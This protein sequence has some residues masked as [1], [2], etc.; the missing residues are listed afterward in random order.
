MAS[1]ARV[2]DPTNHGGMITGPGVDSVSIEGMA[3]AV[4]GDDHTC[5]ITASGHPASSKMVG[6][7][8]SVLIGNR[9]ALRVT[10]SALC[11]AQPV[12]GS[13][14]VLIGD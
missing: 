9:P 14:N 4:V 2:M 13:A 7:S 10:D 6:G 5:P 12:A 8:A 3:A 1:A 11:G